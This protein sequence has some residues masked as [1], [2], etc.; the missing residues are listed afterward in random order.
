M[1]AEGERAGGRAAT[2]GGGRAPAD[3][4]VNLQ[5]SA[6]AREPGGRVGL[7]VQAHGRAPTLPT[8]GCCFVPLVREVNCQE[9]GERE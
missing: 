2:P 3:A 1:S 9:G 6:S 8:C 5:S 4:R 7:H